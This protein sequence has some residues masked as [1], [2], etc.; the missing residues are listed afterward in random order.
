[1]QEF[2]LLTAGRLQLLGDDV[3]PPDPLPGALLLDPMGK[4]PP[5][6]PPPHSLGASP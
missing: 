5:T 2:T 3:R 6:P 1:M 4:G